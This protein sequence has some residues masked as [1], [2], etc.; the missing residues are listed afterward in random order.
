MNN[1][2]ILGSQQRLKC[3]A[4]NGFTEKVN[5]IALRF[6]DGKKTTVI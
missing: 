5:K 4:H 3:G 6:N 2:N 1:K